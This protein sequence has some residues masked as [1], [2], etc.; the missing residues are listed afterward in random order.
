MWIKSLVYDRMS[1]IIFLDMMP[2]S[3]GNNCH[4]HA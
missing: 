4:E 1:L 2:I 3:E